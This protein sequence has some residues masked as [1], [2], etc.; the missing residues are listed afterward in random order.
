[1]SGAIRHLQ[2]P[3]SQEVARELTL[4]TMVTVSGMVFTG[5]SQFHIRAMERDL[6]PPIECPLKR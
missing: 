5:R 4:G 1:M 6:F 2:L 3:L